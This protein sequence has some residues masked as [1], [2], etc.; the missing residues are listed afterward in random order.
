MTLILSMGSRDYI[1]QACDRRLTAG[2]ML[3]NDDA[4]KICNLVFGNGSALVSFTGLAE[5]GSFNMRSWLRQTLSACGQPDYSLGGILQRFSERATAHF[6]TCPDIQRVAAA[7]RRTTFIFSAY[8]HYVD[9]TPPLGAVALVS[10]FE[11]GALEKPND[12]FTI[13]CMNE[14]PE[15]PEDHQWVIPAGTFPWGV[16]VLRPVRELLARRLP[17]EHVIGRAVALMRELANRPRAQGAIG[18]Q[19][20]SCILWRDKP[21]LVP[22]YYHARKVCLTEPGPDIVFAHP[23][24]SWSSA[25]L[26]I[27]GFGPDGRE[28]PMYVPPAK[29]NAPCPCNSGRKYRDCHD[30]SRRKYGSRH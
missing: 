28:V 25:G 16:E 13:T 4:T 26:R 24:G 19:L 15:L 7:S 10:N 6:R 23:D 14:P 18:E 12:E 5:A 2:K 3:V 29:P 22:S 9:G 20:L 11:N 21:G 8:M 17:P 30:V 27:R 1:I